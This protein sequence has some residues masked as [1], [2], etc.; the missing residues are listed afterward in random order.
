MKRKNGSENTLPTSSSKMRLTA[1]QTLAI[2]TTSGVSSF[3]VHT[4]ETEKVSRIDE[5]EKHIYVTVSKES[6][7]ITL[8]QRNL[9]YEFMRD[10]N[11]N[12]NLD[13]WRIKNYS[14]NSILYSNM[15][16][17][18]VIKQ[19]DTADFI[20]GYHGDEQYTEIKIYVDGE[21][22][23][24]NSTF[25][26]KMVSRVTIFV[27]SN[28]YF[29]GTTSTAFERY[30][31]LDFFGNVLRITNLWKYL[32]DDDFVVQRYPCGMFSMN[33]S[34]IIGYTTNDTPYLQNSVEAPSKQSIDKVEFLGNGFTV[35]VKYTGIKDLTYYRGTAS[36]FGSDTPP[37]MKAY[38]MA[39]Y[40]YQSTRTLHT[41]DYIQSEVEISVY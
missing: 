2:S 12:I 8:K 26:E 5:T 39:I 31:Q 20:G 22:V 16:I 40:E 15:E 41:D 10:T 27:K 13:T 32:G 7:K 28:V 24:E 37:R 19:Q 25:A 17:E 18:G 30:K 35:C 36:Y 3:T 6:N 29:C 1:G 23:G 11:Q 4:T 34:D 9:T 21:E 38:L 14:I 33:T